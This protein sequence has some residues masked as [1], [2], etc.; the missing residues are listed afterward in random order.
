MEAQ[1]EEARCQIA[2][3][4]QSGEINNVVIIPASPASEMGPWRESGNKLR[5]INSIMSSRMQHNKSDMNMCRGKRRFN[6]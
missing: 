6:I 1:R 4:T 2:A 3:G 5:E